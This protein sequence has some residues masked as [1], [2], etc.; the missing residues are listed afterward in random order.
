MQA[1]EKMLLWQE[2]APYVQ[3]CCGQ[4]PPFLTVFPVEGARGAVVVCPGGAYFKKA[5]HEGAPVARMLNSQGIAAFVLDYRVEPCPHDAPLN[6]AK[7]AIRLVRSLG[8]QKVGIL[9]FSAGGHVCCSAATLYDTGDANHPDPIERLSSRPDAFIPCYPVASF[10]NH[11]NVGSRKSLLRDLAD[12]QTLRQHYSAEMNVT[13]DTPP[14]FLWHTSNDAGVH[15]HNSLNLA[16]A[17]ADHHVPFEMHIYPQGKHGLG[18]APEQALIST[19]GYAC[20][21]WLLRLGFGV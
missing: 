15:V 18:L 9:G 4:E 3:E 14:A 10:C 20:C 2:N 21:D 8:Y 16:I 5:E 7:R 12:D 13:E 6:D 1:G 17:L 19:W 11:V